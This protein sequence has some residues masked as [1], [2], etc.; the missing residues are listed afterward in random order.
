MEWDNKKFVLKQVK[1]DGSNLQYAS[2]AL[3]DDNAIVMTALANA[4]FAYKYVSPRLKDDKDILTYVLEKNR[5]GSLIVY[6][7]DRLR[8]NKELGLL[9]LQKNSFAFKY[10][11][12]SLKNDKDIV[13]TALRN[14][15]SYHI[16]LLDLIP[17]RMFSDKE[18]ME[19]ALEKNDLALQYASEELRND[20]ELA[21]KSIM[22]NGKNIRYI[23][24]DLRDN[25]AFMEQV[26]Q[27]S[28]SLK[29]YASPRLK[30]QKRD[31]NNFSVKIGDKTISFVKTPTKEEVVKFK[32]DLFKAIMKINNSKIPS[33]SKALKN[34]DIVFGKIA[35]AELDF[36]REEKS[37][38]NVVG[39]YFSYRD[40][41]LYYTGKFEKEKN[42]YI[43]IIHEIAHRFHHNNIKNGFD[44]KEILA[45]YKKATSQVMCRLS[46]FPK[47]GDPLSDL[48]IDET[49]M[50]DHRVLK[51]A[52]LEFY[53]EEITE[54]GIFIYR[55]SLGKEMKF[56][57]AHL[58]KMLRCPSE[59][60]ATNEKE[61]FAE[62]CTLITLD[63]V[64]PN[65]EMIAKIFINIIKKN[66]I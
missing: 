39:T 26:L 37:N 22:R 24:K 44:N 15:P 19:L 13:L 51:K 28:E 66:L 21:L 49:N 38:K 32:N 40:E 6:A 60:G 2:D 65:Q 45:L 64:K 33:F 12:H 34:L 30:T 18:V 63:I 14:Q 25:P 55:D 53:L 1:K 42:P 50:W 41:I 46:Q 9:A 4:P 10:L 59:Y 52:G 47:I 11:Y 61:F 3:K 23:S 20:P 16:E 48:N 54:N 57:K 31:P 56:T 27:I 35:E 7:S 8:S 17:R 62:M 5:D 29:E 36:P 43:T 58:M